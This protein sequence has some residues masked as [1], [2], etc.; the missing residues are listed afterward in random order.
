MTSS[1]FLAAFLGCLLALVIVAVAMTQYLAWKA[2]QAARKGIAEWLKDV[3]KLDPELQRELDTFALQRVEQLP[4]KRV[5][6]RDGKVI[7]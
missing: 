1:I 5:T 7:S 3:S 6:V 4:W 2:R